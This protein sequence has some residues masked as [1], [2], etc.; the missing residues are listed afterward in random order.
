MT[1]LAKVVFLQK[2]HSYPVL[3]AHYKEAA[4]YV[5]E[6]RA[7]GERIDE[8]HKEFCRLRT[9]E[10]NLFMQGALAYMDSGKEEEYTALFKANLLEREELS[11]RINVL[12]AK[13]KEKIEWI[14]ATFA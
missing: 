2:E 3:Q 7:L 6:T 13:S 9:E 12:L 8:L 4:V 5:T 11:E 1:Q 14:N 10:H